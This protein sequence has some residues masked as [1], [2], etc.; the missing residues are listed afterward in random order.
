M[1]RKTLLSFVLVLLFALVQ[2]GIVTHEISHF[3]DFKHTQQDKNTT[4]EHC[5]Q[6][7]TMANADGALPASLFGFC[8]PAAI[9]AWFDA[10]HLLLV[11]SHHSVYAARAPPVSLHA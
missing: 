9:Q 2:A 6:C 3:Q 11:S 8:L 5:A 10:A 7:L 1:L 4:S